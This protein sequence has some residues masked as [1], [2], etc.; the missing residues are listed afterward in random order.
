MR[1]GLSLSRN[2]REWLKSIIFSCA[3]MTCS[4]GLCTPWGSSSFV[5]FGGPC[6]G[7]RAVGDSCVGKLGKCMKMLLG[8]KSRCTMPSLWIF[9]S[10]LM[11]WWTSGLAS[12]SV[13]YVFLIAVN[14][15]F[16]PKTASVFNCYLLLRCDFCCE[17]GS[18]GSFVSSSAGTMF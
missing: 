10:A 16:R 18:F 13:K 15:C 1:K 8:F 17:V 6:R 12:S 5:E 9:S 14:F 3:F 4:I 7:E 11:S 2:M